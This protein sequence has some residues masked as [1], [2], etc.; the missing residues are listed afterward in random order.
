MIT[1]SDN[2][3]ACHRKLNFV[4]T[5]VHNRGLEKCLREERR[6]KMGESFGGNVFRTIFGRI[7]AK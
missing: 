2:W 7:S 5:T 1:A 4:Y 6:M 3:T